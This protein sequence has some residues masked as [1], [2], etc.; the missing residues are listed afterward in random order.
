[1]MGVVAPVLALTCVGFL[2]SP[3]WVEFGRVNIPSW[4]RLMGAPIA[5][6]GLQLF[7]WMF[8]H[9]GLNVTSTSMPRGNATLVTSGPY[10]WIRHPMY[11]AALILVAGAALLTANLVVIVG[12]VA[13]FLLLA[14]RSGVEEERL[15]GKFGEAYVA[16]QRRTGRFIPRL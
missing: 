5:I 8:R 9:L 10:R 1:M 15:V 12:G 6:L 4:V 3:R 16:Y 14:A 11:T 2:I 7:A 13:M